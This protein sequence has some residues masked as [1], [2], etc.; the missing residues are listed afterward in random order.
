M[1]FSPLKRV[2]KKRGSF[3]TKNKHSTHI[4]ARTGAL[5]CWKYLWTHR[6]Q[7]G[8]TSMCCMKTCNPFANGRFS[9]DLG[10]FWK[11]MFPYS[12]F[13]YLDRYVIKTMRLELNLWASQ[14]SPLV[15]LQWKR[16]SLSLGN[17]PAG[18][19]NMGRGSR[20][21]NPNFTMFASLRTHPHTFTSKH[22]H[23]LTY[24]NMH[25]HTH[26][27]VGILRGSS[28]FVSIVN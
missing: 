9:W 10:T 17:V 8:L 11:Q 7:L 24:T 5:R 6:S 16:S 15:E 14:T 25:T 3:R 2:W 23:I 4:N 28:G 1:K 26:T 27:Q 19:K 12:H 21:T 22:P 20:A 18:S 13:F